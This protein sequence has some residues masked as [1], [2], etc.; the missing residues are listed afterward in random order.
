MLTKLSL[1]INNNQR[2]KEGGREKKEGT[3]GTEEKERRRRKRRGESGVV[4]QTCNLSP[5][6]AEA[7]E[8]RV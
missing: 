5:Q 2:E 1:T 7:E 6:E 4:A 3:G 8:S